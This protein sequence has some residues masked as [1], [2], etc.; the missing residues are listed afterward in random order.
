[1]NVTADYSSTLQK[2]LT[3]MQAQVKQAL[4][5]LMKKGS[6][7]VGRNLSYQNSQASPAAASGDSTSSTR[8]WKGVTALPSSAAAVKKDRFP[9][10]SATRLAHPE[11]RG[12]SSEGGMVL[13]LGSSSATFAMVSGDSSSFNGS[14]SFALISSLWLAQPADPGRDCSPRFSCVPV[15]RDDPGVRL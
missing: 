3:H 11:S 13:I 14:E 2:G 10:K 8:V 7:A 5:T 1:M 4:R 6:R 15:A 12:L 9:T